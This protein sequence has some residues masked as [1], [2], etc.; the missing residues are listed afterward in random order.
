MVIKQKKR[1]EVPEQYKWDLSSIYASDYDWFQEYEEVKEKIK[2]ITKYKGIILKTANNLYEFLKLYFDLDRKL[3]KLFMY[4]HLNNDSDTTDNNY[5]IIYG[6]ISNLYQE[7]GELTTF[8]VPELLEKDYDLISKYMEEIPAIKEYK[9]YLKEVFRYKKHILSEKE[10]QVLSTLSKALSIPSKTYSKLTDS[11]MK[12]GTITDENGNQVELT[13]HN[14]S[15]YISSKDRNV[16]IQAFNTMYNAYHNFINT[17]AFTMAGEVDINSNIA[18]LKNYDSAIEMA[19]YDENID[20][21]VYNNLINTVSNNLDILFKYYGL[22]KKVLNLD[23]LHLYDLYCDLIEEEERNYSFEEGKELVLN[24][25]QVLGDDYINNLTKAFDEKWI[26]IYSNLGK[27]SGAYSSG[28]YDTH[29]YLL[30]NYQNELNDVST[31]AHELGHSMHSYYSKSN[32]SYQEYDYTIFVAEVAS[33]VNELL[34]FK[35]MLKNSS[36]KKEK[37]TVLNRLMELFKGTIYRQTMFSEFEKTIYDAHNNEEILTADF[38]SDTYYKIVE[39]YF[40]ENV[41][42]DQDI[43]YEWARIPHFYY[44]FY[45][46]KYATGLSAACYIVNNILEGKEN[47]RENYLE[48]LKTGGRDY[49]I[50]ELK[51]AGVDIT[52]PEVIESALKMF[53]EVIDEFIKVY[54]N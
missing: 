15:K 42:I 18:K 16:R 19:L 7:F 27:K 9:N 50:E 30:L 40:K 34:L 41:V 44:F 24:A 4:A 51:I 26:D 12:L 23:E 37:L 28:G 48:F 45:V 39:K 32:N 53:N 2:T 1:N 49:P 52:K 36:S 31:L 3:E 22:R 13:D 6:K 38:L 43:K 8:I 29:P 11:D 10:E 20:I 5:Q 14:Y 17:I 35:Y 33:T 54:N 47:A 46:Y 21:S 25:L